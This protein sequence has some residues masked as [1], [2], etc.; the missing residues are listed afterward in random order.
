MEVGRVAARAHTVRCRVE[1]QLAPVLDEAAEALM[2]KATS[3]GLPPGLF[4][5]AVGRDLGR[6]KVEATP[7]AVAAANALILKKIEGVAL[8]VQNCF[9]GIALDAVTSLG[10]HRFGE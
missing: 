9:T 7:R 6:I 10:L 2:N 1:L 4:L 3:E 5:T 8:K